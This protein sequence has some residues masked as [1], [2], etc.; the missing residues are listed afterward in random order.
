[1]VIPIGKVVKTVGLKGE[2]KIYP[3]TENTKERFANNQKITINDHGYTIESLRFQGIC[4]IIRLKDNPRIENVEPLVNGIVT[5][6]SNDLP[7]IDGYYGYQLK[8]YTVVFNGQTIG[9]LIDFEQYGPQLNARIQH[10][11]QSLLVPFNPQFVE[12][13]NDATTTIIMKGLDGLL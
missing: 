13:I 3:Y 8:G 12:T 11:N 4:P 7:K 9:K 5:I 2:I 1:M 10:E 6:D